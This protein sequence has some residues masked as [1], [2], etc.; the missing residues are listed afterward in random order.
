[1]AAAGLAAHRKKL[2]PA[3]RYPT[4]LSTDKSRWSFE[5]AF[6]PLLK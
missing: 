1:M 3:E 6:S 4:R 2:R 5:R